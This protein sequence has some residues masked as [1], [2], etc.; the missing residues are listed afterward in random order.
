MVVESD[1][2]VGGLEPVEQA[3]DHGVAVLAQAAA[4]S[5]G[6][7]AEAPHGLRLGGYVHPP[8]PH[9]VFAGEAVA[10]AVYTGAERLRLADGD[11]V[12][13]GGGQPDEIRDAQAAGLVEFG[14]HVGY[15]AGVVVGLR[16][17]DAE[18]ALPACDVAAGSGGIG[19][20]QHLCRL[21][22]Y[23]VEY[24]GFRLPLGGLLGGAHV[25]AD[26]RIVEGEQVGVGHNKVI[27]NV[28]KASH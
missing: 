11:G 16:R 14:Q 21:R 2:G 9:N 1:G 25:V 19:G 13:C 3:L 28:P 12:T 4:G 22:L 20:S 18:Q 6:A 23:A 10:G 8:H 24:G 27:S 17:I 5:T 15:A 26:G 7:G